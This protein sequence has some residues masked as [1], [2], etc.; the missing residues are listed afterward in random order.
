MTE[1]AERVRDAGYGGRVYGEGA[2]G[3]VLQKV[4]ADIVLVAY[5]LD[6]LQEPYLERHLRHLGDPRPF[7]RDC[8]EGALHIAISDLERFHGELLNGSDVALDAQYPPPEINMA[9]VKVLGYQSPPRTYQDR[10]R[11]LEV[12][13]QYYIEMALEIANHGQVLVL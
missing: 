8:I 5:C 3:R 7:Y 1:N 6:L 4:D 13:C 2:V 12:V 10:A 11:T 9:E